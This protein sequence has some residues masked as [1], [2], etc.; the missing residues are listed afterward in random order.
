AIGSNFIMKI[1]PR[2]LPQGY[3]I[4]TENPRVVRLTRGKMTE[5]NFGVTKIHEVK[6]DITGRAFDNGSADLTEKW[7]LGIDRLVDILRKR[8][9]DL[10]II[11][12]QG[13]ESGELAQARV[14]GLAALVKEAFATAKGGYALDVNTSVEPG[15]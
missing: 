4:T 13:G 7:S 11:Y 2:T 10:H 3:K 6:V 14:D 5:I 15:K 8:L 9:S 1:D 12:H